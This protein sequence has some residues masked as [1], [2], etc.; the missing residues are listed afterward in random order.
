MKK[1]TRVS[2][3][4]NAFPANP[5]SKEELDEFYDGNTM[6]VRTGNKYDSPIDDIYEHCIDPANSYENAMLLF[7]HR[8]CG[9]STELNKMEENLTNEGYQVRIIDC[10]TTLDMY[11]M[12]YTDILILLGDALL[13]IAETI[14][15]D[16]PEEKIDSIVD[17]W[18]TT[19]EQTRVK[20][21]D[22]S[23]EAEVGATHETPKL[24][25]RLLSFFINVKADL[26]QNSST[27][28]EY[29]KQ[30]ER[31]LRDWNKN[32]NELADCITEKLDGKQPII[33]FEGLDKLDSVPADKAW[34]IF[35]I[36][37]GQ[38]NCYSFPI[39][40]TFPISL[41]Y[42]PRFHSVES[43]FQYFIMPMIKLHCINGTEY[44]AGKKT[45]RNIVEMR[46]DLDLFDGNS[47][48]LAIEKTGGS[49][50]DLFNVIRTAA[51]FARR[52]RKDKIE[53]NM[54]DRALEKIKSDITR[55]IEGEQYDFLVEIYNGMHARIENRQ[56]L[57]QMMQANA[58]L[59]YN[60]QRWHDV[61]PLVADYLI[62]D[63][64]MT[65]RRENDR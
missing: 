65:K 29:K 58:V 63:L 3:I 53:E 47:L 15:Y 7:G 34:D 23:V 13:E 17:F 30:I 38:L 60:G 12:D 27:R 64:H 32:I 49:L 62:D 14:L 44:K 20:Q 52:G 45:I 57:L 5:L 11:N 46:T 2:E 36:H 9:K 19:E 25:R 40:Y 48:N 61:H 55:R 18:R 33:I 31:R 39:I 8:G 43:Y 41:S 6:I 21:L 26:K 1:A 16:I 42:D 24:M 56:M 28:I 4:P 59:E 50:R 22:K 35:S 54:V 10:W 37:G 51:T